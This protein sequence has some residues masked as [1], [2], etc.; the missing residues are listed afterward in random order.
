MS[1]SNVTTECRRKILYIS[2]EM[3]V[4]LFKAGSHAWEIMESPLPA[5][6]RIVGSEYADT[7]LRGGLK[8]PECVV[9]TIE[10]AEFDPVPAGQPLP[11]IEMVLR[12]LPAPTLLPSA[13]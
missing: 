4:G 1:E 13:N 11:E 9:L 2:R 10:S 3:F 8:Y 5:D 6:A 12:T 7:V